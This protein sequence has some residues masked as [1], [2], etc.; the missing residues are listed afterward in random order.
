MMTSSM[1]QMADAR[2]VHDEP[3]ITKRLLKR[4]LCDRDSMH[5]LK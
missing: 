3:S 4:A 5:L 2:A 1:T